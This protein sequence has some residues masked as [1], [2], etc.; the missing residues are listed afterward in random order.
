MDELNVVNDINHAGNWLIRNQELLL[1]YMINLTSAIIILIAGMFIAKIIS[2][3]VN[4]VLI[5]RRIDATIA[6]FLSALMRYIIIT[7]TLIAALGRIGVQTTSVI[8]I[9]GAAGMAIGLALQGSLSNFA[10]GVLLVTLRPLKTGEY[11]DLGNVS[12]TVLNIH[13]FYTTLR[14]LDG[15]IVVVPNNKIIS[16]NIINYS[17]EPA[18][19]NEFII[20]VSYN[21]DIDL[22]IKTLRTVIENEDR[23]IKDRDIVIGLSELAPSS[24]NFIV[25][26]WSNTTDLNP[27][28]WDLMAEFKKALDKNNINIPYP[29]IDIHLYKKK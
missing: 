23:V 9:L 10:A 25:R 24:L 12:G 16:G 8:A 18:R 19:R 27:V 7:F 4:Q 20:S 22:V 28:Y 6:G 13:I 2:N 5:T 29:Q 11:V 26:C 15:K 17:R 21:S 3:G 14:T 1:E